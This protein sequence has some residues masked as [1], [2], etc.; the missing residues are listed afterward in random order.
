MGSALVLPAES[1]VGSG[2]F[3]LST[4]SSL[5]FDLASCL[6][7]LSLSLAFVSLVSEFF[8]SDWPSPSSEASEDASSGA[9]SLRSDGVAS[10]TLGSA[11]SASS[12]VLS[13]IS[14]SMVALS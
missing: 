7:S 3:A 2:F 9:S 4:L 13:G 8:G 14:P 12:F 1:D 6:P 11:S 5:P 10:L